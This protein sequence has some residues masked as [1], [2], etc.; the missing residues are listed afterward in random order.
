MFCKNCGNEIKDTAKFCDQCGAPT[1]AE[2][3]SGEVTAKKPR[4]P[5]VKKMMKEGQHLSEH[6]V[7][8]DDGVYRWVY[9][10][11]LFRNPGLFFLI[12]K[13]FFFIM[14]G[15]CAFTLLMDV[16]N[17]YMD[18]EQ[19]L[20]TLRVFGIILAVMTGLVVIS[21]L[22]YAAIMGGKYIVM[23]EMD[24]EGINHKQ[25]EAQ[26]RKARK[27]G[28]A[29]FIAGAASGNLSTMGAG[30]NVRTEMYSQYNLVKKVKPY[31]R[32]NLI[33]V[34]NVLQRNQVFAH[35]EDFEFVLNYINERVPEKAR[36]R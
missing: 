32:R 13:V 25:I 1:G 26:A 9:E 12:W 14:L 5:T 21:Y 8:C 7:L 6:M 2:K 15:I 22:I 31:P 17:G 3:T 18:G 35:D 28:S 34:N 19:L 23:F 11:S 36:K 29:A 30:M 24:D 20:G 27:I 10:Y 4:K 16:I 33:K